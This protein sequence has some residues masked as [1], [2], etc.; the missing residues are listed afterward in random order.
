[1][2]SDSCRSSED[3]NRQRVDVQSEL[4]DPGLITSSPFV[5]DKGKYQLLIHNKAVGQICLEIERKSQGLHVGLRLSNKQSSAQV[6][7]SLPAIQ[8]ALEKQ[9]GVQIDL[10]I[11]N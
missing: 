3:G 1:V 7:S 5:D 11:L 9:L 6:K 4:T 8:R 10:E 2:T